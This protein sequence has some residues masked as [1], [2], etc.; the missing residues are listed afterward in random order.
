M[1]RLSMVSEFS[2]DK[3]K[4]PSMSGSGVCFQVPEAMDNDSDVS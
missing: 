2:E 3:W 1:H 4:L